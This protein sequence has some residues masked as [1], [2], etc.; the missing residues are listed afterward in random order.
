MM[1]LLVTQKMEPR[2]VMPPLETTDTG[3]LEV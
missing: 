3:R 1:T 2:F